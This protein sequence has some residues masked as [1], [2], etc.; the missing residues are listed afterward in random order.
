[1]LN[2]IRISDSHRLNK[3]H[4]LKFHVGSWVRQ[5]TPAEGRRTHWPKHCEY[6]NKDEDNCLKTLND[7]NRL[8]QH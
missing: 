8:S 2:R 7:K 5:E 1:M 3:G 6:D 4:G